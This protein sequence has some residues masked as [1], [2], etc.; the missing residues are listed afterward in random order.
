M[1]DINSALL[2]KVVAAVGAGLLAIAGIYY[3]SQPIETREIAEEPP[4]KSPPRQKPSQQMRQARAQQ[5]QRPV[6]EPAPARTPQR[7]Q[8][9]AAPRKTLDKAGLIEIFQ[10]IKVKVTQNY[11]AIHEEFL[12]KRKPLFRT[13]KEGYKQVAKD[14]I[15][16][17]AKLNDDSCQQVFGENNLTELEFTQS[18]GPHM[19]DEDVATAMRAIIVD[20][21]PII[22]QTPV[23]EELTI[24]IFVEC[25]KASAELIEQKAETETIKSQIDLV[26]IQ[27]EVEDEILEKYGY[28]GIVIQAAA[29]KYASDQKT[30]EY[31]RKINLVTRDLMEAAGLNKPQV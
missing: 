13:D 11:K 16:K 22:E 19:Q 30:K 15:S 1:S 23:P 9:F 10:R 31:T 17:H 28:S 18:L 5:P 2:A 27:A 25:Q 7:A 4:K 14:Y 29:K 20:F 24:D 8:T 21:T 3:L 6:Q 12:T 26:V